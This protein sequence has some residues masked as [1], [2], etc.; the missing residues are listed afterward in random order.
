MKKNIFIFHI[1]IYSLALLLLLGCSLREEETEDKGPWTYKV[2]I[3]YSGDLKN[4]KEKEFYM[5]VY[6]EPGNVPK[7]NGINGL[8][9]E[10]ID[11]E[12]YKFTLASDK[13]ENKMFTTSERIKGIDL[14]GYLVPTNNNTTEIKVLIRL[15]KNGVFKDEIPFKFEVNSYPYYNLTM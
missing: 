8:Q 15:Y 9:S 4:W 13:P 7:V 11:E 10:K 5:T 1:W 12:T 6:V 2:E 14:T 3:L